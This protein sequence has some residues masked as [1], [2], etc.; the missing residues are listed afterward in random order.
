MSQLM[1]GDCLELMNTIPDQSVDMVMCDLPYGTTRNKWDIVIPF[2]PL[3]EQYKRICRGPI[4]LT[5]AQPFTA[6]LVLSKL[7]WFRYE[8]IWEKTNGTGF[9]NASKAPLRCHESILVF[10]ETASILYR[11]QKTKGH[12]IKR[13]RA[14]LASHGTNYNKSVSIRA[15][16]ESTE[17]FPRDVIKLPKDNRMQ[18]LH[19]NRKP[20][21]LMEYFIRTYTNEGMAVLDNCMGSGTTGVACVNTKRNFIGIEK[22]AE[23]FK[24][25]EERIEKSKLEGK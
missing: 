12:T 9:L 2:A 18:K 17:R 21:A 15:P 20:V 13:V 24:I 23:Y 22:D 25:A 16:Y 7:D 3:W 6:M 1:H 14:S 10:S 19:P 4:L 11:P 8:W 5:A